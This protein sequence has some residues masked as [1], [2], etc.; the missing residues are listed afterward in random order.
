MGHKSYHIM[1]AEFHK[2]RMS[3]QFKNDQKRSRNVPNKSLNMLLVCAAKPFRS[4]LILL[5]KSRPTPPRESD[6]TN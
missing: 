4:L 2:S 5:K 3:L 6:A 1:N